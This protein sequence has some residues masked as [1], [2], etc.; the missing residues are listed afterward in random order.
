MLDET[1]IASLGFVHWTYWLFEKDIR[2]FLFTFYG[3]KIV[4]PPA[5]PVCYR[6]NSVIMRHMLSTRI[7][8]ILTPATSLTLHFLLSFIV[9]INDHSP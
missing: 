3:S 2:N 4:P 8:R 7:L 5:S 1:R 6:T 9:D